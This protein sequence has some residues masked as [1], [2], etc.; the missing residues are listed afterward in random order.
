MGFYT[1]KHVVITG[2]NRG[3]GLA[4]TTQLLQ[5]GAIVHAGAR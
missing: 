2:A 3:I 1:S 5:Q 4:L